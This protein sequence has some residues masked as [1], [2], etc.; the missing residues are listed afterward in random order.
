MNSAPPL[1]R[2]PRRPRLTV[3]MREAGEVCDRC[4]Q[5]VE[6]G[7]DVIVWDAWPVIVHATTCPPRWTPEVIDGH[8][9]DDRQPELALRPSL[10]VIA[11]EDE[12]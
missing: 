9:R 7:T 6:S 5:P 4:G 10:T 11:P 2:R 1:E 12:P 8:R 3:T